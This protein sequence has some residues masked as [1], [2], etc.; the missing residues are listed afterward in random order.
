MKWIVSVNENIPK[1]LCTVQ[2]D[3]LDKIIQ[4]VLQYGQGSY[5]SKSDIEKAFRIIPLHQDSFHLMG[6]K[7]NNQYFYMTNALRILQSIIVLLNFSCQVVV[8]G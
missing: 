8:P 7:W 2:Y 3:T 6:F 4:L 5:I 1:V